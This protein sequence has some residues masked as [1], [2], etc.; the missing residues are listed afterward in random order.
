MHADIPFRKEG[1]AAR[2]YAKALAARAHYLIM[3]GQT[4]GNMIIDGHVAS[5]HEREIAKD[6]GVLC[7]KISCLLRTCDETEIPILLEYYG[8]LSR[9][10]RDTLPD[11]SLVEH[12]QK[13]VINA[14]LGGNRDIDE[15]VV[16]CLAA[17]HMSDY[18]GDP[19]SVY[20]DICLR[21]K[22]KW[23][24]SLRQYSSFPGVTSY[25]NYQRLALLMRADLDEMQGEGADR[26][27]HKWYEHNKTDGF[28]GFGTALL[29]SYRRFAG[30][31]FPAVLDFEECMDLENKI[32]AELAKRQD[33]D[34]YDRLAFDMALKFNLSML[35]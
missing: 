12:C 6:C 19:G 34:P 5:W 17:A 23:I 35:G 11:R 29:R 8:I 15:S 31:L 20:S 28:S 1:R 33:L 18:P 13:K 21:L 27:K 30:S 22:R 25:E 10:G 2:E 26:E 24:A 9:L 4:A 7:D 14:W 32:L 3:K 16:F